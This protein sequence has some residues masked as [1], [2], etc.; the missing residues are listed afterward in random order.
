MLSLAHC[1][2]CVERVC[3]EFDCTIPIDMHRTEDTNADY[4]LFQKFHSTATAI[5]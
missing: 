5:R 3:A 2:I 4:E 1:I